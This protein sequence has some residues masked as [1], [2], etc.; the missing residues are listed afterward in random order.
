MESAAHNTTQPHTQNE[1]ILE[2]GWRAAGSAG[3]GLRG[4]LDAPVAR[5]G[6]AVE[7]SSHYE[8]GAGA[9][10]WTGQEERDDDV[11]LGPHHAPPASAA[12][13]KDAVLEPMALGDVPTPPSLE[14]AGHHKRRVEARSDGVAVKQ[15]ESD[16]AGAAGVYGLPAGEL[17]LGHDCANR[18]E[19]ALLGRELGIRCYGQGEPD[20]EEKLPC[21]AQQ[22]AEQVPLDHGP[23]QAEAP[24]RQEQQVGRAL[25][26]TRH[27]LGNKLTHKARKRRDFEFLGM[28][29]QE[30]C[31][32]QAQLRWELLLVVNGEHGFAPTRRFQ[33]IEGFMRPMKALSGLREYL[34]RRPTLQGVGPAPV[35]AQG[36]QPTQP[37]F[38]EGADNRCTHGAF[39]E[40]SQ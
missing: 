30:G 19:S 5:H 3:D 28:F 25:V 8:G 15:A 17:Q 10:P 20:D 39:A 38:S 7:Q 22:D 40:E 6:H 32:Q 27:E 35:L 11:G 31:K 26:G 4:A 24:A 33:D 16:V 23:A 29:R 1:A 2:T 13:N 34:T 18:G 12:Q 21:D 36:T 37:G 9:V 14:D